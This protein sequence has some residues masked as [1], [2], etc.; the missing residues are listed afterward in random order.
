MS[1]INFIVCGASIEYELHDVGKSEEL[2]INGEVI[3]DNCGDVGAWG[4]DYHFAVAG[5]HGCAK[6]AAEQKYLRT[7]A[8]ALIISE[9]FCLRE[10]VKDLQSA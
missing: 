6:D 4:D 3:V 5:L 9:I 7:R 2:R 8:E 1:K 10:T